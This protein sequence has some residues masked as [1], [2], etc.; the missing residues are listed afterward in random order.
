MGRLSRLA[1]LPIPF[2]F[3]VITLFWRVDLPCS[4]ESPLLVMSLNFLT[5]TD[6]KS[7]V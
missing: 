3:L 2:L 4:F 5:R 7:V 6:R 1:W